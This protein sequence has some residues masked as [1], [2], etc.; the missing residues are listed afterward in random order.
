MKYYK[1]NK[2]HFYEIGEIFYP[3]GKFK[4]TPKDISISEFKEKYG[5]GKYPKV[6]FNVEV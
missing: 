3:Q 2:F 1:D 5:A 4:P 6:T